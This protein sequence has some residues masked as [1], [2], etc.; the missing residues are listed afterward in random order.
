MSLE[1][2]N[3]ETDIELI[4]FFEL[5]ES[6]Q[7]E[8]K[9]DYDSVEESSFFRYRGQLH[10]LNNFMRLNHSDAGMPFKGFDAYHGDSFFSGT[11]IKLSECGDSLTVA[12]YYS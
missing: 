3:M 5:S 8:I 11:L 2:L 7:N 12:R 4:S 10:D 1:I 9:N 6:E